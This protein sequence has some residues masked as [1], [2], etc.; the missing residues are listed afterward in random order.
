MKR[1]ICFTLNHYLFVLHDSKV[2]TYRINKKKMLHF[3]LHIFSDI[4]HAQATQKNSNS[5]LLMENMFNMS[6]TGIQDAENWQLLCL[7]CLQ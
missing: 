2:T 7:E 6:T 3:K 4:L 1:Q 5:N